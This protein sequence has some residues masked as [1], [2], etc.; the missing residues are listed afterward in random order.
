MGIIEVLSL[1]LGGGFGW[2]LI[3]KILSSKKSGAETVK[4]KVETEG[5]IARQWHDLFDIISKEFY[6]AKEKLLENTR[7]IELQGKE[8]AKLRNELSEEKRNCMEDMEDMRRQIK[9]IQTKSNG[10]IN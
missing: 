7:I 9:L 3:E 2:K 4:I 10:F 6:D 8:I 5:I 1:L